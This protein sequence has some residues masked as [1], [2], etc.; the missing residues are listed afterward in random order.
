MESLYAQIAIADN[1]FALYEQ[2]R[3]ALAEL[4]LNLADPQT[5]QTFLAAS[6]V[7]RGQIVSIAEAQSKVKQ[8]LKELGINAR[9][10][11]SPQDIDQAGLITGHTEYGLGFSVNIYEMNGGET[12]VETINALSA[13]GSEYG[14]FV[15]MI[16]PD[17]SAH[18]NGLRVGDRV[19]EINQKSV[20]QLSFEAIAEAI[21]SAQPVHLVIGRNLADGSEEL[22]E[23]AIAPAP[24]TLAVALMRYAGEGL[25]VLRISDFQTEFAMQDVYNEL[26]IHAGNI[27]ALVIDLRGTQGGDYYSAVGLLPYLIGSGDIWEYEERKEDE[28]VREGLTLSADFAIKYVR[29]N[30]GEVVEPLMLERPRPILPDDVSII[31]VIDENTDD[32][33]LALASVLKAR[34]RASLAGRPTRIPKYEALIAVKMPLGYRLLIPNAKFKP[35][36]DNVYGLFPDFTLPEQVPPEIQDPDLNLALQA[37]RVFIQKRRGIQAERMSRRILNQIDDSDDTDS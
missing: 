35:A 27:E 34:K 29:N 22:L 33:A 4:Y 32:V 3:L 6:Q 13:I 21:E 23:F 14:V 5:R 10:L 19:L 18:F 2:A 20:E 17:S 30:S 1:A 15:H 36:G 24:F 31:I 8:L 28:V 12:P 37:G 16:R 7:D 25:Y 9:F 11:L 26:G